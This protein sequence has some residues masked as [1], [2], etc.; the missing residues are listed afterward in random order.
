MDEFGE[1]RIEN[2]GGFNMHRRIYRSQLKHG[3]MEDFTTYL[4]D[5]RRELKYSLQSQGIVTCSIFSYK[6]ML[7]IYV[8]ALDGVS[9]FRWG[10]PYLDWLEP[11]PGGDEPCHVVR[12]VDIFHDGV[13]E[14]FESWRSNR[15]VDN[16]VGSLARLNPQLVSSYI[17]YHYQKQEEQPESFNKTYIIGLHEQF[18]FSYKENPAVISNPRPRGSLNSNR[19]PLHWQDVMEPHF[20][21]W[22]DEEDGCCWRKME[23]LFWYCTL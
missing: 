11:W 17:F 7:C 5:H 10:S 3:A 16:R 15:R 1:S 12:M 23:E 8:E 19:T 13:P 4:D 20:L 18:I 2:E 14:N 21:P 9:E 6:H 22:E